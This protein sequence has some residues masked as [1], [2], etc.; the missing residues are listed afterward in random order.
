MDEGENVSKLCRK[1]L[2]KQKL[3]EYLAA[4]GKLKP[5][6][7]KP[8]LRDAVH[9]KKP[10]TSTVMADVVKGKENQGPTVLKL[11]KEG[12]KIQPLSVKTV[13]QAPGVQRSSTNTNKQVSTTAR[14]FS[15]SL[16]NSRINAL[17]TTAQS[18]GPSR[19]ANLK[20]APTR[21]QTAIGP[22]THA[23]SQPRAQS[24][25]SVT[26]STCLNHG[27][28]S[29]NTKS[30]ILSRPRSGKPD[31]VLHTGNAHPSLT[32]SVRMNTVAKTK[33]SLVPAVVQP[34]SKQAQTAPNAFTTSI[35]ARGRGQPDSTHTA[36][37]YQR[38]PVEQKKHL[39]V[40]RVCQS[41]QR[42][43]AV[44]EGKECTSQVCRRTESSSVTGRPQPVWQRPLVTAP[45]TAHFPTTRPKTAT[46][47]LG[48]RE[49]GNRA[50]KAPIQAVQATKRVP[51]PGAEVRAN[52]GT[53]HS[54]KPDCRAST[55]TRCQWQGNALSRAMQAAVSKRIEKD[56]V[57]LAEGKGTVS[58]TDRSNALP[59]K[60]K[61][62]CV[63]SVPV[64]PQTVA[65]PARPASQVGWSAGVKT[66][67][68]QGRVAPQTEGKTMTAAQ[69]ERMRRLQ[70]WRE[71]KGISYKR[72]PMP[73]KTR[74]RRTMA[75]P[76]PYWA[77]LEEEEETQSLIHAL[78]RSLDDCIKL[79]LE[80][81]PV[82]KV[83][84]ILSRLPAVA[85]KF[86]KYWICQV[87][88]MELQGFLDVLPVFEQAVRVILEPVDELRT[89]VFDILR[90]KEENQG[91][92]LEMTLEEGGVPGL[93]CSPSE[94]TVDTMATPKPVKALIHGEQ[95][96]SSVV[97]YKITATPGGFRSQQREPARINGQELLFFT[98]VRRSVR[99]EKSSLCYPVAL[100]DHDL[101]VTSYNDLMAKEEEKNREQVEERDEEQVEEKD[102][103]EVAEGEDKGC[104]TLPNTTVYV[105][106]ENEALRDQVLVQL[107]IEEV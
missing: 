39:P 63:T 81:C 6:S 57:P 42:R 7:L 73:V 72:P 71:A 93:G 17:R 4:K 12:G 19:P 79:L 101:C 3:M 70:E 92:S 8:Y 104:Q 55:G 94:P 31:S 66:P 98:P 67:G 74:V 97:K 62:V 45:R 85:Q 95:R 51:L 91:H 69:A 25:V 29:T 1:E 28:A 84:N 105:Y 52:T 27:Q 80:G 20:S 61:P 50:T 47:R 83:Q 18:V 49:A 36:S 53:T 37:I 88:L 34:R 30:K 44:A 10:S 38:A 9:V 2:R 64:I 32:N 86:A 78:D 13:C 60:R 56:S 65:R 107:V 89:V 43:L 21:T 54:R 14:T 82:A 23:V 5:P 33:T 100:Q 58:E 99:I 68:L 11:K 48:E 40:K 59:H 75:L 15:T 76:Q 26:V 22:H 106:R 16:C 35:R 102:G 103:A 77:S 90:K 24:K 87:R 41:F 46:E 96:G